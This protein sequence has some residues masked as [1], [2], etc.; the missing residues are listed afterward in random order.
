MYRK[1]VRSAGC[2]LEFEGKFVILLRHPAKA[3]GG[4]WGLP[5]GKVE[6]DETD[7]DAILR[8]IYEETGYQPK[9]SHLESLGVH[10]FEFPEYRLEF[11]VFRVLLN[12][13]H[14]VLNSRKEHQKF[15]WVTPEECYAIP[16][17]IHGFHDL[18]ERLNLAKPRN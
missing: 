7:E 8:E 18:L 11:S 3:Q 12:D 4:T 16:N 2:F 9:R 14:E 10:V 17:L 1:V 6:P 13:F 5:A 15:K